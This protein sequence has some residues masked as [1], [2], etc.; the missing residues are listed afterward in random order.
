[1]HRRIR[2]LESEGLKGTRGVKSELPG[3]DTLDGC[4]EGETGK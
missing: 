4:L 1:M 3:I 2:G